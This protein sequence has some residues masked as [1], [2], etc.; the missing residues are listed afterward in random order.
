MRFARLAPSHRAA[1]FGDSVT[2]ADGDRGFLARRIE[3]P[4]A[5][6]GENPRAFAP[7]RDRQVLAKIP[8]KKSRRFLHELQKL[9]ALA[10][11]R[12]DARAVVRCECATLVLT[13]TRLESNGG[14]QQSA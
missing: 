5:I 2:D 3:K 8:R 9:W 12:I 13:R 4:A 10:A 11:R 7:N 1:D 14:K 6:G